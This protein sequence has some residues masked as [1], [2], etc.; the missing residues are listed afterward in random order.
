MSDAAAVAAGLSLLGDNLSLDE[1]LLGLSEVSIEDH[2]ELLLGLLSNHIAEHAE[3]LSDAQVRNTVDMCLS[4][5]TTS[6]SLCL[7]LLCNLTTSEKNVGLFLEQ[8]SA[9]SPKQQF[10]NV[11]AR[12]L[13]YNPQAEEEGAGEYTTERWSEVD[14]HEHVSSI[15]CNLS[16]GEAG[17][18][19]LLQRSLGYV[20]KMVA[21]FRSRNPVRRRGCISALRTCLFDTDLHWWMLYEVKVLSAILLPI[22]TPTPYTEAEKKGMDPLV[23]M[24]AESPDTRP[25]PDLGMAK[26][27]LE[28]LLLLCQRRGLRQELRR[29]KVYPVIRNLD[30]YLEN[31]DINAVVLDLVDHL[32]RDEEELPPE[33]EAAE[34]PPPE[35]REEET[36]GATKSALPALPV[37]TT[38]VDLVD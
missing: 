38:D 27:L 29:R 22:V 35:Y 23:W 37:A 32:I 8:I 18:E 12:F 15:L 7:I 30:M 31:D 20:P 6:T 25:E 3:D 21:Q 24:Q 34:G 5:L 28:C 14:P 19:V 9:P 4:K 17:R 33:E 10:Q 16:V 13:S 26:M 1:V 11:V 2:H 36:G